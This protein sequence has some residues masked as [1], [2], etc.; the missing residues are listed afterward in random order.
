M[1]GMDTNI[2]ALKAKTHCVMCLLKCDILQKDQVQAMVATEWS[3]SLE[4]ALNVWFLVA[5]TYEV[6]MIQVYR[7]P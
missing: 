7:M 5:C 2:H 1:E 6:S 4:Q 3:L